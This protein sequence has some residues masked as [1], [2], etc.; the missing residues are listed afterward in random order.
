MAWWTGKTAIAGAVIGDSNAVGSGG[1]GTGGQVWN[2]AIRCYA[3]ENGQT[4][5]S[6]ANL[7]WRD[8]DPNG[9]ARTEEYTSSQTTGDHT[10]VGQILGGNG[11]PGMQTAST[12][13]A[14]T[15]I[16]NYLYQAA[17]GGTTT[18]D[19]ANGVYWDSMER[20]IPG[21]L[22]T[23]PGEPTAFDYILFSLFGNDAIQGATVE[24]SYAHFKTLRGKMIEE[25]WW[26]PNTTQIVIL[27]MPRTGFFGTGDYPAWV[28]EIL[29]KVRSRLND[30]IAVTNSIGYEIEPIFPVHYL[31]P[32]YTDA[33]RQAGEKVLAQI[34]KQRSTVSIGGTRIS[35]GGKKVLVHG[36]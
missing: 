29:R 24:E 6:E 12:I 31:P 2:R 36:A 21:A 28:A 17:V 8:L 35:V 14:G 10:F 3:S 13:Q 18:D 33:G 22:S 30:R 1:F 15:L 32:Y 26:V 34:P 5:Y 19:W 23:I 16:T 20:T 9:T 7:G 4:P 25:G 11:A 27:D